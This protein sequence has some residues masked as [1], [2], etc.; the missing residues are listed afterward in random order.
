MSL[1]Q[2][3]SEF[4]FGAMAVL[5]APRIYYVFNPIYP[6][7]ITRISDYAKRVT[8]LSAKR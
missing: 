1:S 6:V 8:K 3:R 5:K 4:H 7:G 2:P